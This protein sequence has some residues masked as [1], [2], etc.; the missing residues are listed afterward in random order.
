MKKEEQVKVVSDGISGPWSPMLRARMGVN[1][2]VSQT[3]LA[4]SI[5]RE[6]SGTVR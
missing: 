5:E 2:I 3:N 4:Y 6:D 1:N